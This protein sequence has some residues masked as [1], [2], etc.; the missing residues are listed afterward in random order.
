MGDNFDM[1]VVFVYQSYNICKNIRWSV[2][3]NSPQV[4]V[5]RNKM[6]R[7]AVAPKAPVTY[8]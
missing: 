7:G 3:P 2:A 4:S 5:C 6:V 1:K 8:A